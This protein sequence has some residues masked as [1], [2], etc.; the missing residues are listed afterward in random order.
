MLHKLAQLAPRLLLAPPFD[1]AVLS[2]DPAVGEAYN[3]DPLV[4]PGGTV[5][6]LS[7]LVRTAAETTEQ[8][9]KIRVPTLCL[10]G[11]DDELVPTE[12]SAVLEGLPGVTRRVLPNLRH[13]IVNEPEG[14]QVVGDIIEWIRTQLT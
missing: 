8:V 13:E 4:K 14:P 11:G 7:E 2:R 9:A 6:L 1:T 12:A 10:H 3:A 5:N